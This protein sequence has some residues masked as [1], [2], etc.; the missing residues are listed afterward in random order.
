MIYYPLILVQFILNFFADAAP[1]LS[2]YPIVEVSFDYMFYKCR[3][4]FM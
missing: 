3:L 1:R 2:D 4:F